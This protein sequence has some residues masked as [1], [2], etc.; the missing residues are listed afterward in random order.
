MVIVAALLC[1][2]TM[3]VETN[4]AGP[5]DVAV[6]SAYAS[7]VT[8]TPVGGTEKSATISGSTYIL[9]EGAVKF[10]LTYTAAADSSNYLVLALSGT[11]AVPTESNIVY[12]DQTASTSSTVAFTVYPST[13]QSGELYS[14][15]LSSS[16]ASGITTLAKVAS[17]RYYVPFTLGDVDDDG[18]ITSDDAL[19]TLKMA[20]GMDNNGVAWTET[21]LLAAD[22]DRDSQRTSDDALLILKR[23]VGEI[24]SFT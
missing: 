3:A 18:S 20:V 8:L 17:F 7:T 19:S 12:I 14:V 11:S 9:Y 23:A 10:T 5:Y 13:L 15:Y 6:E 24:T 21:Q 16:A 1:M 2:V 22:V 4:A